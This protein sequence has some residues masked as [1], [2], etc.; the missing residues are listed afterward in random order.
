MKRQQI[1]YKSLLSKRRQNKEKRRLI[2]TFLIGA[3]LLYFLFSW[4]L[5][6]LI[7]G[8]SLLNRFKPQPKQD[9]P[10][11]ESATLAPPVLN[12]PFEAT[13]SSEIKVRGYSLP[14]TEVEIYIDDD[15]KTTVKTSPDGSFT[16]DEV[17]LSLGTNNISG[18]TVDDK[19]NK[20]LSS[21]PIQI[22]YDSEKP[23]LDVSSPSDNQEIKGG[24]KKVTVSGTTD[25][26]KEITITANGTRLI[27]N[28]DG[29]FSKS[30]DINEGENN[31]T[32]VAKDVAGNTTQITRKVTY[33]P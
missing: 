3:F 18:K 15:L 1:K 22:N 5:P 17:S 25:S 27:V 24:D 33:Q 12:I 20:S 11:S 9:T 30:L 7:G 2:I 23:K 13:A 31:I 6:S 14:N 10:V 32:V 28:S 26:N 4:F 21:K 16:S 29:N 8:L 19:G